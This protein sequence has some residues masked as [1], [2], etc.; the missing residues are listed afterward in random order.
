MFGK[1]GM[2][3]DDTIEKITDALEEHSAEL[4]V[5]A[6]IVG[7]MWYGIVLGAASAKDQIYTNM[8]E[9]REVVLGPKLR[10]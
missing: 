7:S 9:N 4:T 5:G 10:D 3:V 6:C 8:I 1:I 2:F